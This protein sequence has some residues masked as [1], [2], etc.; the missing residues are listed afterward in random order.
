MEWHQILQAVLSLIFVIG[1]LLLTLW[2][3]KY[4]E[5]KG[6]KSIL[7]RRL[8]SSQRLD[9]VEIR[10]IDARNSLVLLKCD[11]TEHLV[12]L[13]N[14]SVSILESKPISQGQKSDE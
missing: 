4:C 9:V 14:S 1:L 6:G 2:F 12:L 13:G 8:K 10:R 5:Q 7:V 3:F 11:N